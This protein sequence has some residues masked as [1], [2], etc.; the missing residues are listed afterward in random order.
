MNSSVS[1]SRFVAVILLAAALLPG[2]G[3]SRN[4][5]Q[6]MA[7]ADEYMSGKPEGGGEQEASTDAAQG[8]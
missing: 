8:A 7:K 2:A 4:A 3:C 1:R 6:S 5:D